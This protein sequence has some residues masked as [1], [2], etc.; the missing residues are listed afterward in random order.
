MFFF[1]SKFVPPKKW[2]ID[3]QASRVQGFEAGVEN[4][5]PLFIDERIT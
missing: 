5:I 3:L 2:R 1:V 4:V